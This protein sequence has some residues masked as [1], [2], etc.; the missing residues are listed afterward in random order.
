ML[1][2]EHPSTLIT[3]QGIAT[4]LFAQGKLA[5]AEAE[6]RQLS[7]VQRRVLGTD[8]PDTLTTMA[9]LHSLNGLR[10]DG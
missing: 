5:E 2:A 8:H 10:R 1:G 6:F 9:A 3:R 4:V 7:A